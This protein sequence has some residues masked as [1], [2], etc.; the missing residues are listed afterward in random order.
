MLTIA[1]ERWSMRLRLVVLAVGLCLFF[2]NL[3]RADEI[4]SFSANY[5]LDGLGSGSTVQWQFEVPSIL[6]TSTTITSFLNASVGPGTGFKGCSISS[7]QLPLSSPFSGFPSYVLTNFAS[8]CGPGDQF[9]GAAGFFIGPITSNG[10]FS[11]FAHN[12]G[13][14]MGGPVIGTLTISSVPEP[15]ALSLLGTGMLALASLLLF[16]GR[17][18][19]SH[20]KALNRPQS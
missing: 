4:Y 19:R 6:T 14:V 10:V 1:R 18:S 11:V 5:S 3:V 12:S 15:P 13:T 16:Q 8:P 7:V 17:Y 9:D 2:P 20:R